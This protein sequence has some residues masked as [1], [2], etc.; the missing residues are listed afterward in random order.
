M[1]E[2]KVTTNN[3]HKF[4][5]ARVSTDGQLI[6][7]Q[8]VLLEKYDIP[9]SH[10]YTDTM[11]GTKLH[12]PGLDKLLK[13]LEV[14]DI[15]YVESFSRLSRSTKD[16][17]AIVEDL[18]TR[19]IVIHSEK[20]NFDTGTPTGKLMLTMVAALGQF[21][22]DLLSERTK[23]GLEAA[24]A[25]GKCGGRPKADMKKLEVAFSAYDDQKLSVAEICR[26]VGIGQATFYKY[27]KMRKEKNK[28][29]E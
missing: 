6:D 27:N 19:G 10:Y 15:L 26:Q 7:R 20:E 23:E 29:G 14:G 8:L 9:T 22:R 24:R 21:E 11:S 12:R 16:L 5:Y 1:K 3:K 4:A 17:L 28:S 2:I 18:T 13:R 25:R